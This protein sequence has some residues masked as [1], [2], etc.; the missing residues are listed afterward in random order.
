[1]Q[2]KV[3]IRLFYETKLYETFPNSNY[4]FMAWRCIAGTE[5][6]MVVKLFVILIK[7]SIVNGKF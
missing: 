7:T 3:D 5:T 1:M 2:Y 6:Y 4:R